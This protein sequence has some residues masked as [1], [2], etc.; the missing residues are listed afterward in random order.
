MNVFDLHHNCDVRISL[1]NQAIGST[2]VVEG[3][4]IDT[5]GFEALEFGIQMGTIT[6]GV[7]TI[8]L[9]HGDDPAL[10]DAEDVSA[11]ETL[12]DADFALTDDDT[13]KR[14][15]YIGKKRYARI[16][17]DAAT[18]STGVDAVSSLAILAYAHHQPVDD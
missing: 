11:E 7:Y 15:G 2:S 5:K 1:A 16:S 8:K 13:A 18:V 4:I 6:D 10:S 17:I 12:G 9:E 14:I 3:E